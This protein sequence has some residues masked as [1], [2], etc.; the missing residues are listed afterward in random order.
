[1]KNMLKS[2][3]VT[4]LAISAAHVSA[5]TNKTFLM[6]RTQD[7][8]LSREQASM[9]DLMNTRAHDRFG[10]NLQVTGYYSES[11][12]KDALGKYFGVKDKN[13]FIAD[14]GTDRTGDVDLGQII[15]DGGVGAAAGAAAHQNT[16]KFEPKN[17]VMGVNFDYAQC[18]GK[19][20]DGLYMGVQLPVQKVEN[21]MGMT[22]TGPD[23]A[24]IKKYFAEGLAVVGVPGNGGPV[25]LLGTAAAA[26]MLNSSQVALQN[27]KIA[28]KK[29]VTG[30]ADIN[31]TLGYN[32]VRNENWKAGLGVDLAIPTSNAPDGKNLF[33]PVMGRAG[34]W[35]L[36]MNGHVCGDVWHGDDQKLSIHA[37][38]SY[39]YGFKAV[40]KRLVGGEGD[41]SQYAL[42][43]RLGVLRSQQFV[44]AANLGV[45][46]VDVTPG[47]EFRANLGGSYHN[48]GLV[49]GLGYQP[50]W[51]DVE[52]VGKKAALPDATYATMVSAQRALQDAN[53]Q[54]FTLIG[55]GGALA[56]NNAPG[57]A[58]KAINNADVTGDPMPSRLSHRV[59][60][61]LGY[62]FKEWEYPV[63]IALGGH[64]ELGKDNAT[65]DNWGV[66]L[67]AGIGF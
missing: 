38:L 46:D 61:N 57:G 48:G 64:Y 44:P 13:T 33:E 34:H 9:H 40:E 24:A 5:H 32:F 21:D 19:I 37:K 65:A 63:S 45:V 66:S 67:S 23:A 43:G 31:V 16:M 22:V 28:G 58:L 59:G 51:K 56:N 4:A 11:V 12:K 3:L 7:V 52:K 8:C 41:L 26:D 25:G 2:L 62:T 27:L 55:A 30:I 1:M 15:H 6:P 54:L 47:N 49:F 20:L 60:G 18:L 36:G 14:I 35:A 17:R 10:G 53:V 29:E 39:A 42:I 50:G